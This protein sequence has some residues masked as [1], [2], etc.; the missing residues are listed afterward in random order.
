[1]KGA[2]F[3][4]KGHGFAEQGASLRSPGAH[5]VRKGGGSALWLLI[6]LLIFLVSSVAAAKSRRSLVKR[7]APAIEARSVE[8]PLA[9]RKAAE[10]AAKENPLPPGKIATEKLLLAIARHE[11]G[12]RSDVARCRVKG[13]GG[14]AHGAYQIHPEGFGSHT[15]AEVCGSDRLQARLAVKILARYVTMFP[16]LGIVGAVRGYA[17]GNPRRD[18]KAAREILALWRT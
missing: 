17:S 11:S 4:R 15:A 7:R 18:T 1:M 6:F 2:R 5:F 12:F 10:A 16:S 9:F 14:K 3:A 8:A 13:D